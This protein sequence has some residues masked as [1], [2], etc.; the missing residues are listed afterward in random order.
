M[1]LFLR[2]L[3]QK[4]CGHNKIYQV[5]FRVK[6]VSLS[7]SVKNDNYCQ[8]IDEIFVVNFIHIVYLGGNKVYTNQLNFSPILI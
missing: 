4:N 7:F 6:N 5:W 3:S 2:R 1:K 8:E